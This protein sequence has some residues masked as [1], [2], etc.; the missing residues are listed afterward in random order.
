MY[1]TE[2]TLPVFGRKGSF[3][4]GTAGFKRVRPERNMPRYVKRLK[5]IDLT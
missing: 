5:T 2:N 3:S 1:L 4:G